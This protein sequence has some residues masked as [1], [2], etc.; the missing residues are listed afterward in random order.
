MRFGCSVEIKR[1]VRDESATFKER[2]HAP[3]KS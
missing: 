3:Y 2:L 1:E